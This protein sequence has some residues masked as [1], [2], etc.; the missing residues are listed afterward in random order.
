MSTIH[1]IADQVR[2]AV[3][4]DGHHALVLRLTVVL[5][6]L[7]GTNSPELAVP[8]RICGGLMLVVPGLAA[9]RP[10]WWCL[11]SALLLGNW[12]Q[13]Y[14][15]D[16]HRVLDRVL[17]TCVRTVRWAATWGRPPLQD[18]SV[19]DR[20]GILARDLLEVPR[21]RVHRWSLLYFTFLTDGRLQRLGAALTGAPLED[22]Y[23]RYVR[24]SRF[25]GS[26]GLD[27]VSI[28]LVPSTALHITT[29]SMSWLALAL[30][31]SLGSRTCFHT[32]ASTPCG[33]TAS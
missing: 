26:R 29:V 33:T 21:G 14:S 18:R 31:G 13:W 30:E 9:M 7:Y 1:R 27:G 15:I 24:R 12:W 19:A 32:S 5:L 10:L 23:Q 4:G 16:N 3:S 28:S 22:F 20:R 8:L 2:E 25:L 11:V 6:M 17:D